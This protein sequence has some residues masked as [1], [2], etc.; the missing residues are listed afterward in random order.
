M[1]I[2]VALTWWVHKRKG[3]I[4]PVQICEGRTLLIFASKMLFLRMRNSI[5]FGVKLLLSLRMVIKL[6]RILSD[7]I[8]QGSACVVIY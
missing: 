6:E 4:L 2:F 5:F 1:Q 7:L 3:P 8:Y